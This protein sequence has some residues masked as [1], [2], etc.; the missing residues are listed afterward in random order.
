[1]FYITPPFVQ[2]LDLCGVNVQAEDINPGPGKLQRKRQ[3]DIPESDNGDAC[4]GGHIIQ[5]FQKTVTLLAPYT[6]FSGTLLAP[7]S[8]NSPMKA[9]RKNLTTRLES[10]PI[11]SIKILA[12]KDVRTDRVSAPRRKSAYRSKKCLP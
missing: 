2:Q 1:V 11:N 5:L 10:I 9:R 6:I 8:I 12:L 3:P 7:N 4:F